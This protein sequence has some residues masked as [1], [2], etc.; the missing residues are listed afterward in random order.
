MT[1]DDSYSW[2]NTRDLRLDLLSDANGVTKY[3]MTSAN[4][5]HADFIDEA[6]SDGDSHVAAF[7]VNV[8][9]GYRVTGYSLSAKVSGYARLGNVTPG[10]IDIP[11]TAENSAGL[12]LENRNCASCHA[13]SVS[14]DVTRLNGAEVLTAAI[15]N[16]FDGDFFLLAGAGF[17]ARSEPTHWSYDINHDAT[18]GG[19]THSSAGIW[20]D[21]PV[22]TIFTSPVPEPGTYA[23]LLAGLA[24]AGVAARRRNKAA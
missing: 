20:L 6:G 23:M 15:N 11:G 24:V 9:K 17:G 21:T 19:I 16:K 13:E 3:A 8:R 14:R 7:S 4:Y 2:W 5:M 1:F 10:M 18:V 22:L 12:F